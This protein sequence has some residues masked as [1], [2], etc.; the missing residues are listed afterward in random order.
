MASHKTASGSSL[1][2]I[3]DRSR[4]GIGRHVAP[5]PARAKHVQH[6]LAGWRRVLDLVDEG[7]ELPVAMP[8]RKAAE[9]GALQGVQRREQRGRAV[10]DR[11]VGE[12]RALARLERQ[13]WLCP[14]NA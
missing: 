8:R 4:T 9:H 1:I 3:V 7:D 5:A 2:P 14:V 6:D 10:A 12:G 13:S 11:V